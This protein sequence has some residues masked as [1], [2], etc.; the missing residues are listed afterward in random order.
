MEVNV[1]ERGEVSRLLTDH[2]VLSRLYTDG[3]DSRQFQTFQENLTG[4]RGLPTY[5]IMDGAV[6]DQPLVQLSGVVSP[7]RFEAFLRYGLERY[8]N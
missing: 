7:E 8:E 2:F 3:P 5:A 1:F 4:T 6:I